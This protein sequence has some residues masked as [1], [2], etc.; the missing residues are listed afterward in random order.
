MT[1]NGF[2]EM[3]SEKFNPLHDA[4][5]RYETEKARKE[6]EAFWD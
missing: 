5:A 1:F 4:V 2:V 6:A 3:L